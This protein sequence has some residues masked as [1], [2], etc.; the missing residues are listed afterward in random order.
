MVTRPSDKSISLASEL[1]IRAVVE[2]G[3]SILKFCVVRMGLDDSRI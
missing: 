2:T 3:L 1:R